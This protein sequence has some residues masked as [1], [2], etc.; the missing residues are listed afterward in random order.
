SDGTAEGHSDVTAEGRYELTA[1]GRAGFERLLARRER[2]LEDMLADWD[3]NE[4]PDVRA[5]MRELAKSFAST[6]PVR[7]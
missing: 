6:P 2:D 1:E 5:M 3:R 7:G 4:H